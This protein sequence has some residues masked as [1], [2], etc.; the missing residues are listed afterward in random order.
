MINK[1]QLIAEISEKKC[2]TNFTDRVLDIR[3]LLLF[4]YYLYTD[5][6]LGV[7]VILSVCVSVRVL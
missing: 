7:S 6:V 5:T 4:N 1:S 3:F 2:V